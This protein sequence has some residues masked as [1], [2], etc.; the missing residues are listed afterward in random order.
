MSVGTWFRTD[1]DEPALPA[2]LP[3][4]L[5]SGMN[6]AVTILDQMVRG[7]GIV[8]R[9]VGDFGAIALKIHGGGGPVRVAVSIGLDDV[10]T[11]W[12]ADRVRPSRL[13]AE[14]PR[15]VAVRAQGR[16]HGGAV[17]ARRQGWRGAASAE[18]TLSFD[19]TAGEMRDDGLLLVEI[20]ETA[21]PSWAAGRLCA[22]S[23]IGLRIN[24]IEV[25]EQTAP[26]RT[27][28]P[29]GATGCDFTVIQPGAPTA[30]RIVTAAVPSAPPLPLSPRNRVTR[31][32]PARA[33]FKVARAARRAAVRALPSHPGAVE[34]VVAADLI[35]GEPVPVETTRHDDETRVRLTG[36]VTRPVLLGSAKPQ[37]TLSWRLTPVEP[38]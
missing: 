24:R 33:V 19:L 25:R 27:T 26:T 35:T 31:Q 28:G 12:W 8:G 23:A 36:P 15:L 13:A 11:R 32:K 2:G 37:P 18:A 34:E 30:Y 29:S 14:L 6:P 7:N 20:A 16:I 38:A 22:R 21:H 5:S 9:V 17:L 4:T 1:Y 10:A 3:L